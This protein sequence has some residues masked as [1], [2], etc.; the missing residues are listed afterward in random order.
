MSRITPPLRSKGIFGLR[1]PFVAKPGVAYTV[2][3]I[4]TFEEIRARGSD[5]LEL[6]YSPVGLSKSYYDTDVAAGAVIVTLMSA[7]DKPIYVPDTYIDSYPD[8]GN[9]DY[10][11]LIASISLGSLPAGFDTSLLKN[12]IENVV[13]GF[14][15]VQG[16]CNIG[17]GALTESVSSETHAQLVAA[18]KGAITMN[19][20]DRARALK[21]EAIIAEQLIRIHELEAYALELIEQ[22]PLKA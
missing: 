2:Q 20:T 14:I 15:G 9:I 19:N 16:T 7:T 3:A 4:R 8:M 13:A 18:R 6:V 5:V 21:A 22:I 11:W 17:L 12:Q 1:S 10:R